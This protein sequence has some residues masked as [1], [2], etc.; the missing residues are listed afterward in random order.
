MV[1]W[2]EDN[3]KIF[4]MAQQTRSI[5]FVSHIFSLII[6]RS[7][8][9]KSRTMT[10]FNKFW[11]LCEPLHWKIGDVVFIQRVEVNLWNNLLICLRRD[12]DYGYDYDE[13]EVYLTS[14]LNT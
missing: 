7:P 1:G 6:G 2:V 14:T 11:I 8:N 5:E 4:Q 12:Y 10:I 9:K 13:S 3:H